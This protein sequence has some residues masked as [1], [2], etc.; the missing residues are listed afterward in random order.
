[1]LNLPK[2]DPRIGWVSLVN[3]VVLIVGVG[4][5]YGTMTERGEQTR[6][7]LESINATLRQEVENRRQSNAAIETRVRFLE[8]NQSRTDERHSSLLQL[9]GRIDARLERIENGAQ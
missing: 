7:S 5:A 4:V 8:N 2:P 9:L 3:L 6:T 1:M